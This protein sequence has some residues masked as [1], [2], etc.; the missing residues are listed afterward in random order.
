M[1]SHYDRTIRP[2]ITLLETAPVGAIQY[3]PQGRG[4]NLSGRKNEIGGSIPGVLSRPETGL[5][6]LRERVLETVCHPSTDTGPETTKGPQ[7]V[8]N[9]RGPLPIPRD[10]CHDEAGYDGSLSHRTLN[11]SRSPVSVRALPC[12]DG[13][14][15]G[16]GTAAWCYYSSKMVARAPIRILKWERFVLALDRTDTKDPT[17]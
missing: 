16:R 10:L 7:P 6:Q 2:S 13:D 8:E 11:P 12:G 9:S 3:A 4:G 5:G 1:L 14:R 15:V 17:P